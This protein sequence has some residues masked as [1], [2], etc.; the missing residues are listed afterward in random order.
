MVKRGLT[1]SA[2]TDGVGRDCL[3]RQVANFHMPQLAGEK[4]EILRL[5]RSRGRLPAWR[6]DVSRLNALSGTNAWHY[7]YARVPGVY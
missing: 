5:G 6:L 4:Y 7:S 3:R 1:H 2:T